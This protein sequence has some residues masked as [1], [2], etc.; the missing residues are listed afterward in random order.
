MAGRIKID[1][2]TGLFAE[3]LKRAADVSPNTGKDITAYAGVLIEVDV[4]EKVIRVRS[5]DAETFYSSWIPCEV[6]LLGGD[7]ENLTW[8]LPSKAFSTV[9]GSL[10][11]GAGKMVSL[12]QENRQLKLSSGKMQASF[13][14][15]DPDGYPNWD[16]FDGADLIQVPGLREAMKRVSWAVSKDGTPPAI[17]LLVGP[18]MV[19]GFDG[20]RFAAYHLDGLPFTKD[21]C[22]PLAVPNKI[23]ANLKVEPEIAVSKDEN[24]WLAQVD[25]DTQYSSRL[26]ATK[27]PNVRSFLE[28][29]D[30]PNAI[31]FSRDDFVAM[32][33]RA[34]QMNTSKR[35]AKLDMFVGNQQLAVFCADSDM[36]YLGDAMEL[37]GQAEHELTKIRVMPEHFLDMIQ[38]G[39]EL[40]TM[41]YRAGFQYVE[42]PENTP[43]ATKRAACLRF[44]LDR[45][46]QAWAM[47]NTGKART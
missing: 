43:A 5:T 10:P 1:V 29:T 15:I 31:E 3:T 24:N 4:S 37:P 25:E 6:T 39:G 17:G 27:W 28:R 19:A 30:Q 32:C 35:T 45:N 11:S 9:I 20:I 26:F 21:H 36:G 38:S 14:L 8:R 22:V 16:P 41:H 42:M 23:M 33:R 44:T 34:L 18:D 40:I 47:P 46:Y 2:E 7:M 12:V 13:N